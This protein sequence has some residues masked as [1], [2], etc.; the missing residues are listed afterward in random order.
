MASACISSVALAEVL[1]GAALAALGRFSICIT[2]GSFATATAS[3]LERRAVSDLSSTP[4][5]DAIEGV[6]AAAAAS[7]VAGVG[8]FFDTGAS[9]KPHSHTNPSGGTGN[10]LRGM[11]PF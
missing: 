10:G 9:L 2:D 8:G 3:L 5:L 7:S 1:F 4:W 6:E 11:K